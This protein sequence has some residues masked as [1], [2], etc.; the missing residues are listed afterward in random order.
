[1]FYVLQI[2]VKLG[3]MDQYISY[4]KIWRRGM[5]ESGHQKPDKDNIKIDV[6]EIGSEDQRWVQLAYNLTQYRVFVSAVLKLR[7]L[8]M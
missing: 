7:A 2:W 6:A 4:F 1:M 5:W 3:I 8:L